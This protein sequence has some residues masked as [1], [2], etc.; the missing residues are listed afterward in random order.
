MVRW[1][2]RVPVHLAW[3][4]HLLFDNPVSLYAWNLEKRLV[5]AQ[6][7]LAWGPD[8]TFTIVLQHLHQSST[9]LILRHKMN[10]WLRSPAFAMAALQ[11]WRHVCY[12]N[13]FY[14]PLDDWSVMAVLYP[15]SRP[16]CTAATACSTLR[17]KNWPVLWRSESLGYQESQ[18]LQTCSVFAR[19]DLPKLRCI[20]LAI[21]I[22]VLCSIMPWILM[23]VAAGMVQIESRH[24]IL[25]VNLVDSKVEVQVLILDRWVEPNCL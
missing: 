19:P 5:Q 15:A 9:K 22:N 17:W 14:L 10:S 2:P 16:D 21:V 23:T 12:F 13:E 25:F 4:Q 20:W 8:N 6:V 18:N 24:G 11:L 7:R 1:S 3:S